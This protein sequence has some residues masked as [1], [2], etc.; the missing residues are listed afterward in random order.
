MSTK[1][2]RMLKRIEK[3]GENL[4][5]IFPERTVHDPIELCKK[6]R[7]LESKASRVALDLCNGDTDQDSADAAF[8]KLEHAV[9]AVLGFA[10]SDVPV[11]INR[12]P[13]GYA[14]KI[15]SEWTKVNAPRLYCDWGGY[16]IIAPDL[17]PEGSINIIE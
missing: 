17:T 4:S 8:E 6:L 1:Q 3:H 7:R 10:R 15:E 9:N 16:G 12:D 5:I 14:L 11:F 2:E 13:R